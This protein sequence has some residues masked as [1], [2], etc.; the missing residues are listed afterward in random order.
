MGWLSLDG[1]LTMFLWV[2]ARWR[3]EHEGAALFEACDSPSTGR[4]QSE[5][6][7]SGRWAP[8]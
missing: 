3:L 4:R 5:G 1:P 2:S 8:Q 7:Y 6:L